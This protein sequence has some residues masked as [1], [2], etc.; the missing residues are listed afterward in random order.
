VIKNVVIHL[1]NEQ[2]ML[3]DLFALPATTDVAL[4]CTNLRSMNG[5]RPVF[6]DDSSSYFVFP[7]VHVRFLEV[8]PRSMVD[9]QAAGRSA[10]DGAGQPGPQMPELPALPDGMTPSKG[11]EADAELEIDEDFL[12]R[13]RDI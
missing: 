6:I 9:A 2:P 13:I 10:P 12:K 11:Q 8:P 1:H 5:T 4:V 3:A 7:F